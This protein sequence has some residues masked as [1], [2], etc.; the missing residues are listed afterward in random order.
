[1]IYLDNSATTKPCAEA[2]EAVAG[3]LTRDWGN[4]SALY[5]FGIYHISLMLYLMGM[6]APRRMSGQLY[7]KIAMDEARRLES[8]FDVEELG[9]GLV[10]FDR[11]VTMDLFESWAVHLDQ[12]DPGTLLGSKGGLKLEP[13]SFHTTICD[14]EL[15]CTG[16]L[17]KMNFRWLNTRIQS[18]TSSY[19]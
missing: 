17:E 18:R 19:S 13:F 2:V 8:G 7:Q 9:V 12:M 15:D 4:P 6:P 14:T 1:M 11:Q 5:D 16:D 10:R 3:A